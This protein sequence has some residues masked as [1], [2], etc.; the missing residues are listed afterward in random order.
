MHQSTELPRLSRD[1]EELAA[2]IRGINAQLFSRIVNNNKGTFE[3]K[4]DGRRNLAARFLL[5]TGRGV[6]SG[7]ERGSCPLFSSDN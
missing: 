6:D 7:R 1:K 4:K 5:P 3:R 2:H